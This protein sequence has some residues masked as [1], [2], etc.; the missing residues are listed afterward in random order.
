VSWT[1]GFIDDTHHR[2]SDSNRSPL[3]S[4]MQQ[5]VMHGT[6]QVFVKTY[7][8]GETIALDVDLSD[9]IGSVK[10][11]IQDEHGIPCSHQNR[12][13][14]NLTRL[15]C[16]S[17]PPARQQV[18]QDNLT[19]SDY[20]IQKESTLFLMSPHH[21]TLS[22]LLVD[23]VRDYFRQEGIPNNINPLRLESA[24]S[25]GLEQ[26][27]NTKKN[28]D[29]QTLVS[30]SGDEKSFNP[31]A[32]LT[33]DFCADQAS[34]NGQFLRN[35]D[36]AS[37]L[38]HR[39][40]SFQFDPGNGMVLPNSYLDVGENSDITDN[41]SVL[42]SDTFFTTNSELCLLDDLQNHDQD[43]LSNLT[44]R[45][46]NH[47]I[48][49][50]TSEKVSS[51]LT[52]NTD[53]ETEDLEFV[54]ELAYNIFNEPILV[55]RPRPRGSLRGQ[56]GQKDKQASQHDNS[57]DEADID[58]W[59]GDENCSRSNSQDKSRE[60][61]TS[62]WDFIRVSLNSCELQ[63]S[64]QAH[65]PDNDKSDA[66]EKASDP[67]PINGLQTFRESVN[68]FLRAGDDAKAIDIVTLSLNGNNSVVMSADLALFCFT[69]LRD[70]ARKRNENKQKILLDDSSFG[71]IIET[72][73]LY[74]YGPA[75]ILRR[76]C[77]VLKILSMDPNNRKLVAQGGGCN[78][79]LDAM[80]S[81]VD[82]NALQIMALGSLKMLSYTIKLTPETLSIV[83]DVMQKHIRNLAIQS[84]GC[85]V[86]G[87]LAVDDNNQSFVPITEK[88]LEA[89]V[90]GILVHTE[91]LKVQEAASFA[92]A[93]MARF[94]VNIKL[95]KRNGLLKVSLEVM[96]QNIQNGNGKYLFK[97][98]RRLRWW[99]IVEE[100]LPQNYN[101]LGMEEMQHSNQD[102]DVPKTL[103]QM[104]QPVTRKQSALN[105]VVSELEHSPWPSHPLDIE[106]GHRGDR[107]F[108]SN[109]NQSSRVTFH[110]VDEETVHYTVAEATVAEP[111]VPMDCASTL[112]TAERSLFIKRGR[113]PTCGIQT[114]KSSGFFKKR[115]CRPLSNDYV[116]SGRCLM[117]NPINV[118][119]PRI[120]NAQPSYISD[121]NHEVQG[122]HL[123]EAGNCEALPM[124]TNTQDPGAENEG[125]SDGML[126]TADHPN[127]PPCVP[128]LEM[129]SSSVEQDSS[130]K[131]NDP[132]PSA[133]PFESSNLNQG[134]KTPTPQESQRKYFSK[135]ESHDEVEQWLLSH[136]PTLQKQDV[137]KYRDCFVEDG[138]D[139]IVMLEVLEEGDLSFMKKAH[140]RF[141]LKK[142][143]IDADPPSLQR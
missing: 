66:C 8:G 17:Y 73:R 136:L 10:K 54:E 134:P 72:M 2:D 71:A 41:I 110:N 114:H 80:S 117:C 48:R 68:L 33:D 37:R 13:I 40:A 9:T 112:T 31:I 46:S 3:L 101:S 139:S 70:L 106:P 56:S 20:N 79:I 141:L 29:T 11:K 21:K 34:K 88:G 52:T 132:S 58:K 103:P 26:L 86:L 121:T 62:D 111:I 63:G 43:D 36:H 51:I 22:E 53:N 119:P 76:G 89:I 57:N 142:L 118:V 39:E 126:Q 100:Q 143:Q 137:E 50:S 127:P 81:D 83:A 94:E 4:T 59:L 47:S 69:T 138:F 60:D 18:L 38:H 1:D 15:S 5:G 19:L 14:L 77:A 42:T 35:V 130:L 98:L 82:N 7:V 67:A 90:H 99:H 116:L 84:D 91:S 55:K 25:L 32:Q 85:V 49:I 6:M 87:N 61:E 27:K 74:R 122:G 75:E 125:K 28:D 97:L 131:S 44:P 140:R 129:R 65:T 12:L 108:V 95:M 92:L 109:A 16:L 93:E 30:R 23:D 135:S 24:G 124:N 96:C 105:S 104:K 107:S 128:P 133:P 102:S 78:A 120:V 115:Y 64:A 123:N 113:C 45:T